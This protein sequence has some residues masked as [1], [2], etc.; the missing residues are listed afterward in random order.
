[1]THNIWADLEDTYHP[2]IT[3]TNAE[4]DNLMAS[5]SVDNLQK[6]AKRR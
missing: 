6:E 4:G 1:M 5:L 2:S 3:L